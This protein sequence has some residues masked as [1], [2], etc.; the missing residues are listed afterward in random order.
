MVAYR[1]LL[2]MAAGRALSPP[3]LSIHPPPCGVQID[4]PPKFLDPEAARPL[5]SFG[6]HGLSDEALAALD[7][8]GAA[9]TSGKAWQAPGKDFDISRLAPPLKGQQK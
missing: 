9:S 4:G 2:V 8:T 5:A 3:L 7:G 1:L 6:R